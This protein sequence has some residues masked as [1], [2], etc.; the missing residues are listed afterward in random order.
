MDA[1]EDG[2]VLKL[3]LGLFGF[4]ARPSVCDEVPFA[5]TLNTSMHCWQAHG[6]PGGA[7]DDPESV[8][9][10]L[11]TLPFLLKVDPET[12]TARSAPVEPPPDASPLAMP[13][14]P[15]PVPLAC[16][17]LDSGPETSG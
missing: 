11:T 5:F 16:E 10:G 6:C 2:S 8:P 12:P 7:R 13:P 17:V 1:E 15:E 9:D 4:V 3:D 14:D